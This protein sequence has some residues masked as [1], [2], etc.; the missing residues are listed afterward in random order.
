MQWHERVTRTL[1]TSAYGFDS[2]PVQFL[3]SLIQKFRLSSVDRDPWLGVRALM[4]S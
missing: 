4:A 2:F 3:L 1:M